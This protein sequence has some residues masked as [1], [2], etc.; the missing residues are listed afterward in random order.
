MASLAP[1]TQ[2]TIDLRNILS[3]SYL[4]I[5]ISSTIFFKTVSHVVSSRKLSKYTDLDGGYND[6]KAESELGHLAE[7]LFV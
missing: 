5:R 1:T 4:A 6:K 7:C 2:E 3:I